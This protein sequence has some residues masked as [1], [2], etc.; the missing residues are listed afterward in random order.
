MTHATIIP[1]AIILTT[2][3]WAYVSMMAL[4]LIVA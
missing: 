1:L 3:F 4:G 2:A